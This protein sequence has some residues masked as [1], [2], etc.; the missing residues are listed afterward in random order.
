MNTLEKCVRILELFSDTSPVL[1]VGEIARALDL[2]RSTAYRYVSALK[3][4]GLLEQSPGENGYRLGRRIIELAASMSRKPLRELAL[5]YMERV[6]RET[7]ETVILCGIRGHVGVCLEKV[8]GHHAL[9]V[10]FEL[11]ETYPLHAAAT[12]KAIFAFLEPRIQNDII[13]DVGLPRFTATTITDEAALRKELARIRKVGF[14]ESDGEAIEGTRGIAVPIFSP[15]KQI[16]A[17][18][19]VSAPVHRVKGEMRK[20]LMELLIDAGRHI[21]RELNALEAR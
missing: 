12:G 7:G 19:G 1:Q 3:R 14:A 18:L 16:L 10:S 15:S 17:S 20:R 4:H 2:P 6:V 11:G 8:D 21:T 9:R 5:P 13:A